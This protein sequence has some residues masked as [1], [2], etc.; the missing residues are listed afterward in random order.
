MWGAIPYLPQPCAAC[1]GL[2][3]DSP[4]SS[5]VCHTSLKVWEKYDNNLSGG[6]DG[7]GAHRRKPQTTV[8]PDAD[9]RKVT[10]LIPQS[11]YTDRG[12]R[13]PLTNGSMTDSARVESKP[14]RDK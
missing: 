14:Q 9:L 6:I 8:A 10:G 12:H 11:N 5:F 4:Q 1:A 3:Q 13:E 7:A 2:S